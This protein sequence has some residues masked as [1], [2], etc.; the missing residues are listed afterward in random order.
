MLAVD[1]RD[2]TKTFRAGWL[3]RRRTEALRGVSLQGPRGAIFGRLGPNAT[4]KTTLLS[5]LATLL[6][7]D[8][9]SCSASTTLE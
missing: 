5:I 8:S 7:P 9:G 1:A 6:V 4:G 2:L 3:H